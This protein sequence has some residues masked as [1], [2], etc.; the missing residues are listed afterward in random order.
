M[1][2]CRRFCQR[3]RWCISLCDG[4]EIVAYY[5]TKGKSIQDVLAEIYMQFGFTKNPDF[6]NQK[7]KRRCRTNQNLMTDSEPI[8]PPK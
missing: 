7:R 8:A 4:F 5:K 1:A 6:C 2:I 3:Q